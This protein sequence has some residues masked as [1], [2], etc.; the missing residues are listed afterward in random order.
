MSRTYVTQFV[1]DNVC[2]H[3][4]LYTLPLAP[5]RVMLNPLSPLFYATWSILIVFFLVNWKLLPCN[6][7]LNCSGGSKDGIKSLWVS[8]LIVYAVLFAV[9]VSAHVFLCRSAPN[10]NAPVG[11]L[12]SNMKSL[13]TPETK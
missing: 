6:P 8:V 10:P 1:E 3:S 2:K 7:N 13:F 9:A 4:S 12:L 5:I 11:G